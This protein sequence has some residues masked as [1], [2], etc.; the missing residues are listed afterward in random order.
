MNRMP[1][2]KINAGEISFV[3]ANHSFDV[4]T[5]PTARQLTNH[6]RYT[7]RPN[8]E[9]NK[10]RCEHCEDVEYPPGS[11]HVSIPPLF[12]ELNGE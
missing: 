12:A 11:T 1:V 9:S 3:N 4:R 7:I 10:V 5:F 8:Y 6:V 2:W